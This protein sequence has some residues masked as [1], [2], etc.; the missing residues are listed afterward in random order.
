[1]ITIG[2]MGW[3]MSI[4]PLKIVQDIKNSSIEVK[5]VTVQTRLTL[6]IVANKTQAEL[7][8]NTTIPIV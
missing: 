2:K 4:Y 7:L 1:M 6:A 5:L 3:I 8:I